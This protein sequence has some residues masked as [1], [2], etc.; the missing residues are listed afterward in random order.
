MQTNCDPKEQVAAWICQGIVQRIVAM[1]VNAGVN[2]AQ[3]D[4][5]EM[6]SEWMSLFGLCWVSLLPVIASC[7]A[8]KKEIRLPYNV[9]N[10]SFVLFAIANTKHEYYIFLA[11]VW[12]LSRSRNVLYRSFIHIPHKPYSPDV[13]SYFTPFSFF[14]YYPKWHQ[15]LTPFR[16]T[17]LLFL[18]ILPYSAFASD[19]V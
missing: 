11:S 17:L 12:N 7:M 6:P 10:I 14:F 1:H 2:S 18:P 15:K 4:D 5:G 16:S 13:Y 8:D 19:A 3:H 9:K